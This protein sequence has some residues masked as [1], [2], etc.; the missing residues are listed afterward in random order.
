MDDLTKLSKDHLIHFVGIGGIGLSAIA[1]LSE[2]AVIQFK[3]V[4]YQRMI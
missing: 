2:N 1:E 3:E 4:I